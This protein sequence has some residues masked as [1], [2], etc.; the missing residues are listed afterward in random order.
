[1]DGIQIRNRELAYAPFDSP[2]GQDYFAAMKCGINMSFANWQVILH[3]IR[4]MFSS[5]FGRS[6][7]DLGMHMVYDVAHNT[8]KLEPHIVDGQRRTLLVHRKGAT[9]V[10]GPHMEGVPASLLGRRPA[11]DYWWQ[12]GD[13]LL[14]AGR[15]PRGE[16][17]LFQHRAWQRSHHEPDQGGG[18][19]LTPCT[20]PPLV[21]NSIPSGTRCGLM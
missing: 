10:F 3:R 12:H 15:Y 4:E 14:Y 16:T 9:R 13:R 5:I 6:P 19:C 2:E 17:D 7:E 1:M 8:A 21:S 20:R 18:R 11:G